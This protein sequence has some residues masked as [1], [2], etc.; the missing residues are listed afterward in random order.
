M[1]IK[2]GKKK[3]ENP[4]VCVIAMNERGQVYLKEVQNDVA[5]K[6]LK[7]LFIGVM[8]VGDWS[9]MAQFMVREET[10][11]GALLERLG[12][13]YFGKIY[14]NI[15]LACEVRLNKPGASFITLDRIDLK[16]AIR[17]SEIECGLSLASLSF[18]LSLGT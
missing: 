5:G 9:V 16:K 15:V 12:G 1:K 6:K 8:E 2:V 3:E 17:K 7:S 11:S 18:F 10:G 4:L 14:V 13:F